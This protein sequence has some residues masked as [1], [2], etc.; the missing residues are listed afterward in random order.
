MSKG[1][2][3]GVVRVDR[4]PMNAKRWLL[5]LECGHECWVTQACKPTP[6]QHACVQ[7]VNKKIGD[8]PVKFTGNS[9]YL[10]MSGGDFKH[11]DVSGSFS[12]VAT[13]AAL[14]V[15]IKDGGSYQID[16]EDVIKAAV[17]HHLWSAV[18]KETK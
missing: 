13:G 7:C 12:A 17:A 1:V 5:E 8:A 10:T 16:I 9:L 14:V 4:S 2:L 11:G 18:V 3:R 6:K 15:Y